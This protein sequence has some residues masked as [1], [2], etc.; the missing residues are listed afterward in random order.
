MLRKSTDRVF[1]MGLRDV[2]YQKELLVMKLDRVVET[3]TCD[4]KGTSILMHEVRTDDSDHRQRQ[5]QL[6]LRLF[7]CEYQLKL[8]L[9]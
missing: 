5:M 2:V 3:L 4:A 7:H 6:W 8:N 1:N 9:F